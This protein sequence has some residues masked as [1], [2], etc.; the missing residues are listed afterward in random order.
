MTS[1]LSNLKNLKNKLKDIEEQLEE[2]QHRE[3]VQE[4]VKKSMKEKEDEVRKIQK[5]Q[6]RLN[7]GGSIF[8]TNREVLLKDTKS[9]FSLLLNDPEF[10]IVDNELFFDRSPEYFPFLLDYLRYGKINYKRFNKH[11]L[12]QLFLEAEFYEITDIRNYLEERSK[13]VEFV[14]FEF[15]GKYEFEGKVAGTNN[16]KHL[17]DKS[18][19]K[20][21]C[22]NSPGWIVIELNCEWDIE[23]LDIGGY[24]GDKSLWYPGNGSGAIISVSSNKKDWTIAGNIPPKFSRGI[25]EAKLTNCENVKYIKFSCKSYLGIGYLNIYKKEVFS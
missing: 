24:I 9:V 16:V 12:K 15:S 4:R 19:K 10:K 8:D 13:D 22:A 1:L 25:A 17:K 20:G 11:Q 5:S 23:K 2:K 3:I 21:I 18:M 6:I 7:I 14:N